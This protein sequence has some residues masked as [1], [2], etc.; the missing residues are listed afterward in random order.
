M[1]GLLAIIFFVA[2][3]TALLGQCP[4]GQYN[5]GGVCTD[6]PAGTFRA[7]TGGVG[8]GACTPCPP[9]SFNSAT[10]RTF[11]FTCAPGF[12]QANV[13]A[14]SCAACPAGS[15]SNISG[16]TTCTLCLPGQAQPFQGL[17]SCFLCSPG[18]FSN[19]A[20]SEECVACPAGSFSNSSGST[21]CT[22][23]PLGSFQPNTGSLS[24]IGCQNCDDNN[25]S[26]VDLCDPVSGSCYHITESDDLVE[27]KNILKLQPR[28][29]VPQNPEQG[30]IYFDAITQ[31]LRVYTSSGWINLH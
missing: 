20:G 29:T 28:F 13:G 4:A 8:I 12:F 15:Y 1:K 31:K 14:T 6:C 19:T 23:C 11:C 5:D 16:A 17:T 30:W 3:Y 22:D 21:S 2:S 27:I 25:P 10:G 9:G 24:C 18:Y 26:T 7:T